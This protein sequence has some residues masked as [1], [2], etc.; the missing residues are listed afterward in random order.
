[1]YE[2]VRAYPDGEST[3]ARYALAAREYGYDGIVV[4]THGTDRR[5]YDRAAVVDQYGIDVVDGVTIDVDDP[6]RA[7]GYLGNYRTK[8]TIVAVRGG[9]VPMNRF[10][11]EQPKVDVLVEPVADNGDIN[12]VI[13][14]EA[15]EHGVRLGVDLG[16]VLRTAGGNRV[17][18]LQSFQKLRELIDQFDVPYVVTA[19]PQS[20]RQLRSPRD[21]AALGSVLGVDTEWIE[22][23]LAEWGHLAERNRTLQSES[24]IEPGVRRGRYETEP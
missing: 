17:Q 4:R 19:T 14:K 23:G 10:A 16:P 6:E 22:T 18:Y 15:V 20:H 11:V 13:A 24:F 3:V 12:H 5:A 21:L 9:S 7:S 1:M 8:R 2:A